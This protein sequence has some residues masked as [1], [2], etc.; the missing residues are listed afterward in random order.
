MNYF[1]NMAAALALA[2]SLGACSST[3]GFYKEGDPQ[4]GEFSTWR[5]VALPFAVLGVALVG[6]AAGAAAASPPPAPAVHCTSN[7]VGHTTYT[8]CY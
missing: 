3:G 5:T 4:N 6:A 2:A 7:R 1:R 8:N